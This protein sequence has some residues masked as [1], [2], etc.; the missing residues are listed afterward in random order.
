MWPVRAKSKSAVDK[1]AVPV[2]APPAIWKKKAGLRGHLMGPAV[3][4][5]RLGT[6]FRARRT[7]RPATMDLPTLSLVD[8]TIGGI[9]SEMAALALIR[10]LQNNGY[11]PGILIVSSYV[12][13]RHPIWADADNYAVKR[14]PAV[15]HLFAAQAPTLLSYRAAAVEAAFKEKNCDLVILFNPPPD[16][17]FTVDLS[18]I[19]AESQYGMG[20]FKQYPAGPMRL[21]VP[22]AFGS[23]Q[24]VIL[25]GEGSGMMPVIYQ[26]SQH[27]IKRIQ[28]RIRVPVSW[29][30]GQDDRR[31][32]F[33]LRSRPVLLW[34]GQLRPDLTHVHLKHFRVKVAQ[35][36]RLS[37]TKLPTASDA[38]KLLERADK[39]KLELL[40][41]ELD[42]IRLRQT[43]AQNPNPDLLALLERSHQFPLLIKFEHPARMIAVLEQYLP[44]LI[45]PVPESAAAELP[46]PTDPNVVTN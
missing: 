46:Q 38:R 16:A 11:R 13:V 3:L 21:A 36:V 5:R 23:A 12:G 35:L 8:P 14:V 30:R 15:A 29:E 2:T 34:S 43:C 17:P 25:M 6:A 22:A 45:K 41:S 24:A 37:P 27:G 31:S 20:N 40:C 18:I 9:G 42:A 39:D 28:S 33:G 32:R 1:P 7:I 10:L 26:A 4:M 19:V 44:S